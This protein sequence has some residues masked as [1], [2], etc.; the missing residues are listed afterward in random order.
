ML[1]KFWKKLHNL[2]ILLFLCNNNGESLT[3][4]LSCDCCQILTGVKVIWTTDWGN[5]PG[6][7]AHLNMTSLYI[8]PTVD[9]VPRKE[10]VETASPVNGSIQNKVSLPPYSVYQN[11]DMA[12]PDSRVLRNA[13][14]EKKIH[15]RRVPMR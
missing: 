2:I 6:W 12:C 4:G 10:E 13:L 8:L 14:L 11:R 7:I 9:W 3:W 15:F 1:N 5:L